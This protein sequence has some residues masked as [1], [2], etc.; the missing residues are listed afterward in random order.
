MFASLIKIKG[1][2]FTTDSGELNPI[3]SAWHLFETLYQSGLY[4]KFIGIG[5]LI[6]GFLLMTQKYAKLGALLN[7]PIVLNIFVIT[8]SYYFAFTP[9]ITG[10]LLLANILLIAWDWNE[11]RVLIN[12]L[13][14]ADTRDRLEKDRLWTT[15][16]LILFSFTF[17]YRIFVDKYDMVFWFAVCALIGIV[18]LVLGISREKKRRKHI[19]SND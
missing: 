5:Q 19:Q 10:L 16:G 1:K 6:A 8:L 14:R 12:L 13:P 2:R 15:V 7:L 17:I 18:G 11:L 4:W 3:D 9:V